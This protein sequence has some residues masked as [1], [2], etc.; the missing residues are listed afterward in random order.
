MSTTLLLALLIG[1]V[2]GLRSM[3]APAAVAWGVGLGWIPVEQTWAGFLAHPL[4]RY[5]FSA[6]AAMELVGDKLPKT[7]S[8]KA[9]GPFVGRVVSGTVCGAVLG[10]ARGALVPGALAG[11]AGAV[12]GTLGGYA[13]RK[14]LA[15][16][17]GRDL[18]AALAE[19]LIAIGAAAWIMA[20]AAR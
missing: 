4:A 18:P 9:P 6:F 11:A 14:R 20:S 12:I 19:D 16:T 17:L 10:T 8:R 7:P 2:A 1:V 13:L 15:Q 3:L 5:V